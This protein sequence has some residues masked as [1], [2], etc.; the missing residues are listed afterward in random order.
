M[1]YQK[2]LKKKY[3]ETYLREVFNERV[4]KIL[5]LETYR[6]TIFIELFHKDIPLI[7]DVISS[8][9][10][11]ELDGMV[12]YN[13]NP[14]FLQLRKSAEEKK[15]SDRILRPYLQNIKGTVGLVS[16]KRNAQKSLLDHFYICLS[17]VPEIDGEY[18]IIGKVVRGFD[19]LTKV[20]NGNTIRR[21]Y[22]EKGFV[23]KEPTIKRLGALYWVG[24]ATILF[25]AF[26]LLSRNLVSLQNFQKSIFGSVFTETLSKGNAIFILIVGIILII[27]A[28]T[29]SGLSARVKVGETP[30]AL[31]E[32]DEEKKMLM[33]VRE[34][35]LKMMETLRKKEKSK[36][37][38]FKKEVRE[39]DK[40]GKRLEKEKREIE[41]LR[42][43]LEREK[44]EFEERLRKQKVPSKA[45]LR[46]L[47]KGKE[48]K[49]RL[50][51]ERLRLREIKAKRKA[52][53]EEK[54]RREEEKIKI[55][56]AKIREKKA[57]EK[58]RED[59]KKKA[60]E[61]RQKIKEA[62]IREKK[63]RIKKTVKE[64]NKEEQKERKKMVQVMEKHI[65]T[66]KEIKKKLKEEIK[67]EVLPRIAQ[68]TETQLDIL[69]D[70]LEKYKT[71]KLDYIMKTFEISKE[72]AIE[73]CNILVENGLAEL[74]YPA[75]GEPLLI[76][77]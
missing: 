51:K 45:E 2:K 61:E 60:E 58:A 34:K 18:T 6:G 12:F 77:K 48:E 21:A 35:R 29:V 71:L 1:D 10:L 55:R 74:K 53:E 52:K 26:W 59:A 41:E 5:I 19:I 50:K 76:K 27:F 38:V 15:M 7:K 30:T 66:K 54:K 67:R 4:T 56:E 63:E 16:S 25:Y 72:E 64:K 13:C 69:Y 42:K 33:K 9:L 8:V 75:F 22:I 23:G 3:G 73:W 39:E 17:D 36:T 32:R 37:P 70:L 62:K 14:Y 68:K 24:L 20:W 43:K 44:K 46:E 28:L 31:K 40:G 49:E 65:D 47:S 11:G 57:R